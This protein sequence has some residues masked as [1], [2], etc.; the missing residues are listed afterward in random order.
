[1][2]IFFMF[3]VS[4]STLLDKTPRLKHKNSEGKKETKAEKIYK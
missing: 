4:L 2:L 1:M 3:F